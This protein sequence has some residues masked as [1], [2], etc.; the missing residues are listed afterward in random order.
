MPEPR[1]TALEA[2]AVSVSSAVRLE[3]L[4]V[5]GL[6]GDWR[7]RRLKNKGKPGRSNLL[8]LRWLPAK[9]ARA[10]VAG[11]VVSKKVGKAVIRNRIRRRLREALRRLEFGSVEAM[12]VVNPEAANARYGDLFKALFNAAR[13]AGL[14]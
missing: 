3:K 4:P 11:I 5:R 10:V 14:K 12:I 2:Q 7:F 8:S 13:K 9:N 6:S 1:D